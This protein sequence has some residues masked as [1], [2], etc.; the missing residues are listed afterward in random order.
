VIVSEDGSAFTGIVLVDRN[1]P[2]AMLAFRQLPTRLYPTSASPRDTGH[3]VPPHQ[4]HL[5]PDDEDETPPWYPSR[6]WDR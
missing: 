3:Y 1:R 2:V 6:R 5:F 4:R